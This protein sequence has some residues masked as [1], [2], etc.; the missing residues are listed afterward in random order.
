MSDLQQ[1]KYSKEQIDGITKLLSGIPFEQLIQCDLLKNQE[2]SNIKYFSDKSEIQQEN[3]KNNV[4]NSIK[5]GG[6]N[7][8]ADKNIVPQANSQ[9][10]QKTQEPEQKK[11]DN[12]DSWLDSLLG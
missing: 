11:N 8:N 10:Q 9:S 1:Y 12:L 5:V 6:A 2:K 7:N 3:G 4:N